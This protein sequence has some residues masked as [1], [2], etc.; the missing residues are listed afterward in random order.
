VSIRV[1]LSR[2]LVSAAC[3]GVALAK[4]EVAD[5]AGSFNE[6]GFVAEFSP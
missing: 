1:K 4:P 5:E 6:G 2:H 3:L